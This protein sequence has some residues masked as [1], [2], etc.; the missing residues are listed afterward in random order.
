MYDEKVDPAIHAE[1]SGCPRFRRPHRPWMVF[2]RI[3]RTSANAAST[4]AHCR[5]SLGSIGGHRDRIEAQGFGRGEPP[6]D[7]GPNLSCLHP[8]DGLNW[9]SS[10]SSQSALRISLSSYSR[11]QRAKPFS[12]RN[13]T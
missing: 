1:L 12:S 10:T 2:R 6:N 8:R 13:E 11:E 5:T 3:L 9:T 7:A 4:R